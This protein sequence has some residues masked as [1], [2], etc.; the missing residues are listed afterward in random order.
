MLG[1]AIKDVAGNPLAPVSWTFT[2]LPA[3]AL[4]YPY[5]HPAV[6]SV[7]LG[8]RTPEQVKQNLDLA[9]RPVPEALWDELRESGLIT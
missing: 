4:A 7:V 9:A 3:A 2:T 6:T 8:M 1:F 5:R